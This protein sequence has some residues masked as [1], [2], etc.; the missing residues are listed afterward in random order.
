MA[1]LITQGVARDFLSAIKHGHPPVIF[2]NG[3]FYKLGEANPGD[4]YVGRQPLGIGLT[5]IFG[6]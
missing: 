6:F 5:P 3:L 1:D 4:G 2:P